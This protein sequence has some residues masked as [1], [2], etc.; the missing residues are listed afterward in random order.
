MAFWQRRAAARNG[1]DGSGGVVEEQA[2]ARA[3][4]SFLGVTLASGLVVPVWAAACGGKENDPAAQ[5]AEAAKAK[6]DADAHDAELLNR[7]IAL[8]QG[9]I[10]VY[11]AAAGLPFIV[12]DKTILGV[13]A[14][15]MGQHEEH[16]DHL[17]RWVETLGGK[18]MDPATAPTPEIPKPILDASLAD[19]VR[20]TAVLEFARSLE[21]AAADAYF[22]LISNNLRTDFA[23]RSAAAILPVEAQH[24]A[25]YDFVLGRAKPVNAALYTEQT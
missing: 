7:G 17:V 21:K 10:N 18:A 20:K 13:A 1:R 24:V 5:E 9:A 2:A 11:K 25:L 19:D 15:F 16:R 4:R 3:R 12:A 22:G 8:E 14:L 23:R 6:A